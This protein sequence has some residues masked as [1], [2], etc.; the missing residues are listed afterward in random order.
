MGGSEGSSSDGGAFQVWFAAHVRKELRV[1][2]CVQVMVPV[3]RTT[4]FV[5]LVSSHSHVGTSVDVD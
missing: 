1:K 3:T 4:F 2:E 5:K